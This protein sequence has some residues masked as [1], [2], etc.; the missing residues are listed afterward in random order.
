MDYNKLR[1]L[2]G[3]EQ[4]LAIKKAMG[5]QTFE[6]PP[7]YWLDLRNR[8][9]NRTVGSEEKGISY[10]KTIV[11]A[12]LQSSGKTLTAAK[13]AGYAQQD[14]AKPAWIDLED[15]F[16]PRW[17]KIHGLDPG[18]AIRNDEG[19]IIGFEKLAFFR[20]EFVLIGKTI[21]QKKSET[22]A[23]YAKRKEK[24]KQEFRMEYA[25]ETF[26]QAEEWMKGQRFTDPKG[27]IALVVDSTTAA[28]PEME[29]Q[30]GFSDRNMRTKLSHAEFL[31]GLTK[32]WNKLAPNVNAIIIYIAQ[33][34]IN[35]MEQFGD[36]EYIPGGK[37]ILLYPHS[38]NK[39]NRVR[40]GLI[41]VAD[42]V[43]GVQS[44]IRNIKNKVGGGSV[45][46]MKCGVR[47]MFQKNVWK[48]MSVK[49]LK[50]LV[51]REKEKEK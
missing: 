30:A 3:A 34:R 47:A 10:G 28:V 37:G 11:F 35:P 9:F 24:V 2:T 40:G 5:F 44:Q 39:M 21:K 15:S 51:D 23:Q 27:K 17:V 19:R 29:E 12:G 25:E 4:V 42:E 16:D 46:C 26:D 20:P 49:E 31:N 13:I 18:K 6:K 7:K 1:G 8:I 14:G 36:P 32:K 43:V 33:L 45:E 41:K 38:I 22:D 48:F 50:A